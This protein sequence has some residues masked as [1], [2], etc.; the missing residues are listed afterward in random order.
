M[1]RPLFWKAFAVTSLALALLVPLALVE[2]QI[3]SRNQRQKEVRENVAASAAGK[4]QLI[5]PLLVLSYIERVNTEEKDEATGRMEKKVVQ[6]WKDQ[7]L[8][9]KDLVITGEAR[10]EERRR[11]LYKAQLF[12][13]KARLSGRFSVPPG[14]GLQGRQVAGLGGLSLVLNL[15]DLRGIDNR[16]LLQIE[17][18]TYEFAPGPARE[19]GLQGIQAALGRPEPY[20]GREIPF[21]IPLE[22]TGSEKLSVAPVAETTQ[23]TLRSEWPSP[24]FGGRFLP[25]HRQV[26][27]TGFEA[28]WQVF[29]LA[30]NLGRILEAKAFTE[31][32]F[33]VAF[34]EPVN[35]YLQSERAVKYGLLFVGLTFAAFFFFE[36]LKRLPIHPMQ[37]LLVGLALALFFLLLISLSE[38]LSFLASYLMASAASIAL[39]SAYLV[40]VLR[41]RARG[42]GFGAALTLL[43]GVLYGLL[44][45]EDNALLMGAL[46]LFTALAAVMMATRKLD[47]YG[48]SKGDPLQ[49]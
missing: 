43:F 32:A 41:S 28:R 16:P 49:G 20:E 46:L 39:L 29:H 44:A 15:S 40:H 8:V 24:S 3:R 27:A 35:V 19:S 45:S 9:P 18:K 31:E 48:V 22:L 7:V 13:W 25:V 5:G 30:R 2:G 14:F 11:G 34:I 4:Q 47:W 10:V 17:G 6:V 38:H 12:H 1:P 42:L 21:E 33:E 23:V 37:Y 36:I 26:G